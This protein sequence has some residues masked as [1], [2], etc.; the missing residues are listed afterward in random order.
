MRHLNA[1][2]AKL[3]TKNKRLAQELKEKED[4]WEENEEAIKKHY[5]ETWDGQVG[6]FAKLLSR[7]R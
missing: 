6:S 2:L 1:E 7:D 3:R 5:V 4:E